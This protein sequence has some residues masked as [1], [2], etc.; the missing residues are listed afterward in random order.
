M[1][2]LRHIIDVHQALNMLCDISKKKAINNGDQIRINEST[3]ITLT[4]KQSE[5][6][7]ITWY[8]EKDNILSFFK[9]LSYIR[10]GD[11]IASDFKTKSNSYFIAD[12]NS[13]QNTMRLVKNILVK[14][15]KENRLIEVSLGITKKI[16]SLNIMTYYTRVVDSCMKHKFY[17]KIK[18]PANDEVFWRRFFHQQILNH[19]YI[20]DREGVFGWNGHEKKYVQFN[21]PSFGPKGSKMFDNMENYL[22]YEYI[23]AAAWKDIEA[24]MKE[25]DVSNIKE[26][27]KLYF[28][29]YGGYESAY[30]FEIPPWKFNY[31]GFLIDV[32]DELWEM[33]KDKEK[34][35]PKKPTKESIKAFFEEINIP[36]LANLTDFF[37]KSG[38]VTP[39][40]IVSIYTDI[41]ENDITQIRSQLNKVKCKDLFKELTRNNIINFGNEDKIDIIVK[42]LTKERIF[43]P[44]LSDFDKLMTKITET[45]ALTFMSA[46]S[47]LNKYTDYSAIKCVKK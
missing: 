34:N 31:A 47:E 17:I 18:V 4:F 29:K 11:I 30:Y 6:A 1:I 39:V 21:F 43:Y 2:D 3:V 12:I 10:H 20:K 24:F 46:I 35:L 41:S 28:D 45:D 40:Q 36:K 44:K 32:N 5:E 38:V 19:P 42:N 13:K 15:T 25:K 23:T 8:S 7:V 14:N 37:W 27:S 22:L 26:I 9:K 33:I 16:T